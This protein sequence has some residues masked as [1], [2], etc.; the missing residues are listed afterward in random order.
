MSRRFLLAALLGC[1]CQPVPAEM[2]PGWHEATAVCA[3][4]APPHV[5]ARRQPDLRFKEAIAAAAKVAVSRDLKIATDPETPI[6]LQIRAVSVRLA[7]MAHGVTTCPLAD[8]LQ[9]Q[10]D[11]TPG[12]L[13]LAD[14]V[15]VLEAAGSVAPEHLTQIL[16][17]GCA[18]IPACGRE[19]AP[20]LAA[21]AGAGPG[22]GF[23]ELAK[24][25]GAFSKQQSLGEAGAI[26]F[27]RS[28]VTDFLNACAPKFDAATAARV[29]ELRARLQ[30]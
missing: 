29:Q 1:A 30:L 7:A 6:D 16:A 26:S 21:M 9:A 23:E 17:A 14:A 15:A 20:G 8:A 2:P 10:V 12:P 5:I 22:R 13:D 19:C 24:G 18:E 27:T 25:C 3:A 28:R 4:D 11:A